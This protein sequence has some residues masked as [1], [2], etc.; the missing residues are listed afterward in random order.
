[1]ANRIPF[2][3]RPNPNIVMSDISMVLLRD[4]LATIGSK[5]EAS[6]FTQPLVETLEQ[7]ELMTGPTEN[8]KNNIIRRVGGD[9]GGHW[10]VLI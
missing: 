3:E 9:K 7:M 5:L 1:M 2:D 10:E 8:Q 6:L 4:Y